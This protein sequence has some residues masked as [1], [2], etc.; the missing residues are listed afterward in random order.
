MSVRA[1][2]RT[3]IEVSTK[4]TLSEDEVLNLTAN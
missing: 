2:S 1:Q 3:A 4:F